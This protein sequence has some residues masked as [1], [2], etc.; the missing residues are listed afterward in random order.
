M[1]ASGTRPCQARGGGCH[2]GQVAWGCHHRDPPPLHLPLPCATWACTANH[3]PLGG[4]GTVDEE[5][6]GLTDPQ[7]DKALFIYLEFDSQIFSSF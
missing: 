1:H 7:T 6:Y 4:A 3:C 2:Q 5:S